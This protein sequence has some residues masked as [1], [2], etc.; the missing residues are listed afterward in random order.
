MNVIRIPVHGVGIRAP[1]IASTNDLVERGLSRVLADGVEPPKGQGLGLPP[2]ER[3]RATP[4]TRLALDVAMD[5]SEGVADRNTL[6]TLFATS[7]GEVTVIHQIFNMLAEGDTALSPTAFHNSV[8]NAAAGYWSIAS[9][10]R[11]AADSICAFDDSTGAGLADIALRY[12]AG[13]RN[14]LLVGYD[15]PP[16]HPISAHRSLHHAIAGALLIGSEDAIAPMAHLNISFTTQSSE[17]GGGRR[18]SFPH[19]DWPLLQIIHAIVCKETM[20][21]QLSAGFGGCL[22]VG[23]GV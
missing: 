3:R 15:L 22:S 14:L 10:S 11:Y 4:V 19:P 9:G 7:G 12:F 8:H 1:G 2:T 20:N 6:T 5:A 21:L 17:M 18:S 16:P 13:E 23:V